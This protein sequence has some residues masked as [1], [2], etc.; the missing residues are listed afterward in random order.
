MVSRCPK[1]AREI[2]SISSYSR[3]FQSAALTHMIPSSPLIESSASLRSSG[4]KC[5][6][7][8]V[9]PLRTPLLAANAGRRASLAERNPRVRDLS[10]G[11]RNSAQEERAQQRARRSVLDEPA[12]CS[13][14]EY[15]VV[16]VVYH[17]GLGTCK[18]TGQGGGGRGG[19][20]TLQEITEKL[21]CSVRHSQ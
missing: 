7:L 9:L 11:E 6:L 13:R 18:T 3:E 12:G 21:A 2:V 5:L 16:V 4:L 19:N 1:L 20:S 14:R 17:F 10:L 15:C 8:H